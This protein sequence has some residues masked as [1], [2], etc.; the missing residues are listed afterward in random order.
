MNSDIATLQA[1]IDIHIRESRTSELCH[2][3]AMITEDSGC[4]EQSGKELA[5]WRTLYTLND[6]AVD[7]GTD[8]I[9][10]QSIALVNNKQQAVRASS[11]G[12]WAP[13]VMTYN[14]GLEAQISARKSG[15]EVE[16]RMSHTED[17][18]HRVMTARV[19]QQ[20]RIFELGVHA[21]ECQKKVNAL[22]MEMKDALR[23]QSDITL[24]DMHT[25]VQMINRNQ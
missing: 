12:L 25:H 5:L 19:L 23:K 10:A 6:E 20:T 13:S 18:L 17:E 2:M 4:K 11:T 22:Q 24:H 1:R 8:L 14:L 16:A 3:Q 15:L 21:E 9:R 7:C